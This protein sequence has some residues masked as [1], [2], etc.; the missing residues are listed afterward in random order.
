M[1]LSAE[2]EALCAEIDK[3]D[4][5]AGK[6]QRE[7]LEKFPAL[8]TVTQEQRLRQ[9]DYDKKMNDSKKEIEYGKTMKDWADKNVPKFDEMKN[10]RDTA[11]A[12]QRKADEA[13][14][15]AQKDLAAKVDTAAAAAGVDPDKLAEA[16][17]LKIGGDYVP[18]AELAKLVKDE[19]NKLVDDG[20]KT[21][22][23][24]FYNEDVPR[25]SGLNAAL[26]EGMNRF[27]D[28]F[29]DHMD[30]EAY[31]AHLATGG[32][33]FMTDGKFDRKKAYDAFVTQ[34]RSDKGRAAEIEK[35]AQK[36]ADKI[37]EERGMAGGFPGTSGPA[38]PIQV[39]LNAKSAD[40]PLFGGKMALGDGGAAAQAAAELHAEGK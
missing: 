28:E 21:A 39:R 15:K 7:A 13:L 9:A 26:T 3:V 37:M 19:A 34:Q 5:A 24:K 35:E 6:A 30:P 29:G 18:K 25:L 27:H 31:V 36:R 40:D 16:V 14:A 11:V 10:E 4:P 38:G 33:K 12:A 17:R 20:L 1:A 22:T 32:D 2:L 8:A 23:N